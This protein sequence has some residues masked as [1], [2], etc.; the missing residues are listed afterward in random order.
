MTKTAD[1]KAVTKEIAEKLKE[2]KKLLIEVRDLSVKHGIPTSFEFPSLH[3]KHFDVNIPDQYDLED[4]KEREA[5][6]DD[7]SEETARHNQWMSSDEYCY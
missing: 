6:G 7:V 2:V 3:G 4:I 1:K 5:E